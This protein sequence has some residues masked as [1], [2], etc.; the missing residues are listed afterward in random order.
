MTTE[1]AFSL[2]FPVTIAISVEHLSLVAAA[3]AKAEARESVNSSPTLTESPKIHPGETF[4]YNSYHVTHLSA[5][6]FGSFHGVDEFQ[7][8]I[9]IRMKPFRLDIPGGANIDPVHS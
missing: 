1:N 3:N 4:S 9:H 8:R 5:E 7:N 6:A 2:T